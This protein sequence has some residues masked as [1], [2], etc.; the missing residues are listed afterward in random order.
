[1]RAGRIRRL[2]SVPE[3]V[4]CAARASLPLRSPS[5]LQ[6]AAIAATLALRRAFRCPEFE[7]PSRRSSYILASRTLSGLTSSEDR[8]PNARNGDGCFQSR[9]PQSGDRIFARPIRDS[10]FQN[11]FVAV[12]ATHPASHPPLR[13]SCSCRF[14]ADLWRKNCSDRLASTVTWL[15]SP[16]SVFDLQSSSSYQ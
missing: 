3:P 6:R 9:A 10:I 5:G 1:M 12:Q 8:S 14:Q 4:G 2:C 7:S 16:K 15:G 13:Q 11:R